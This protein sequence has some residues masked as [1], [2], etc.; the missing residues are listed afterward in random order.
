MPEV[1][2]VLSFTLRPSLQVPSPRSYQKQPRLVP[3]ANVQVGLSQCQ[4]SG[5][6][7]EQ[8][9]GLQ[10][11]GAAGTTGAWGPSDKGVELF[12]REPNPLGSRNH[13]HDCNS[14][15]TCA[16]RS[17]RW[18]DLTLANL[19]TSWEAGGAGRDAEAQRKNLCPLIIW[20][21][22]GRGTI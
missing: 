9:A 6:K 13:L 4:P 11:A 1:A 14:N 17:L 3:R 21:V 19:G 15:E 12:L 20:R 10:A 22:L 7:L 8:T 2:R 16:H 18:S 5:W